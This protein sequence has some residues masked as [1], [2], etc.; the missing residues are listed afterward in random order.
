MSIYNVS[1]RIRFIFWCCHSQQA[2]GSRLNTDHRSIV[3]TNPDGAAGV[4][5]IEFTLFVRI[6]GVSC[7]RIVVIFLV[8]ITFED[9]AGTLNDMTAR[10]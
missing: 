1:H 8:L 4:K 9:E 6:I 7:R 10:K 5:M 3:A 2:R